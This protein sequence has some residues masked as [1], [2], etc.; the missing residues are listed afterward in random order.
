MTTL[1]EAGHA[2]SCI[3]SLANGNQSKENVTLLSGQ[4]L[5]ANTVLG[6]ITSGGKYA[7]YNQQSGDG[8][9]TAAGILLAAADATDGD[10]VVAIVAR[11]AEVIADELVWP[12]G[13]PSDVTAGIADLLAV[14]ILVRS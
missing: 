3:I 4:V 12:D 1:T 10:I 11:D 9:G 2:G 8:T 5:A 14:G 13:S 6:K 7:V